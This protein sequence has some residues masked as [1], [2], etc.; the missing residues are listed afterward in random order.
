MKLGI[1]LDAVG[2]MAAAGS[3]LSIV[4]AAVLADNSEID[5]ISVFFS[6]DAGFIK[7]EEI[8]LL[9]AAVNCSLNLVVPPSPELLK[10]ILKV[11]PSVC[12]MVSEDSTDYFN[13]QP[14]DLLL[15]K[16]RIAEFVTNMKDAG[17]EPSILI[18]PDP[19]YL[20][21]CHRIGVEEVRV[22]Y[23]DKDRWNPRFFQYAGKLGIKTVVGSGMASD[24][25]KEIVAKEAIDG[26]DVCHYFFS[27]A[28]REGIAPAVNSIKRLLL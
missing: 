26:V 10:Y 11:K 15:Y 14:V 21:I 28:V 24:M 17:I 3:D 7:E 4:Q 8:N 12:T 18:E 6:F 1:N 23:T 5:S 20:K 16:E 27:R 2:M 13:A 19:D 9:A 22:K 25:L